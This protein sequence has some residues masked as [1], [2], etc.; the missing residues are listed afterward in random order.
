MKLLFYVLEKYIPGSFEIDSESYELGHPVKGVYFA[1]VDQTIYESISS[2]PRVK[3]FDFEPED[4][5]SEWQAIFNRV[6]ET[7]IKKKNFNKFFKSVSK[8]TE[9]FEKDGVV[10]SKHYIDWFVAAISATCCFSPIYCNTVGKLV[11]RYNHDDYIVM[12]FQTQT[13]LILTKY[14]GFDG[15]TY[16]YAEP[17]MYE[18]NLSPEYTEKHSPT[19]IIQ[20]INE[21]KI[22][23]F[24]I[25]FPETSKAGKVFTNGDIYFDAVG[26]KPE[27]DFVIGCNPEDLFECPGCHR[28][29]N[30]DC[31]GEHPCECGVVYIAYESKCAEDVVKNH[32]LKKIIPILH[33]FEFALKKMENNLIIFQFQTN[34]QI[35]EAIADKIEKSRKLQKEVQDNYQELIK[36]G[37]KMNASLL[38]TIKK[39]K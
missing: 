27:N 11:A 28:T 18:L 16:Y 5:D 9:Y 34:D 39:Y 26:E 31:K 23:K 33:A 13:R 10:V 7:S 6:E 25:N 8:R 37:Q 14:C 24:Q 4:L 32:K 30:I 21:L 2:H 19:K 3:S 1:L 35:C 17:N 38:A 36:F 22:F 15:E 20:K 12:D 29:L